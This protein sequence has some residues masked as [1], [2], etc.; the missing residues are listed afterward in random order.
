[1]G[2]QNWIVIDSF[3]FGGKIAPL[4]YLKGLGVSPER[5]RL[6]LAT[7][8]H[9]D[10]VRGLAGLYEAANEADLA[11]SLAL[12]S[13]EFVKFVR[14]QEAGLPGPFTSGVTELEQVMLVN[15]RQA[16][17]PVILTSASHTLFVRHASQTSFG[18]SSRFESLSPSPRDIA[19]FL[20]GLVPL[21]NARATRMATP[22][23]NEASVVGWAA[24]GAA[25]ALLGADLENTADPESGWVA[26]VNSKTLPEGV[27]QVFKVP[28]HGSVT[29]HCSD[30][31]EHL[32]GTNAIAALAPWQRGRSLP[33]DSDID[34]LK[35]HTSD[36]YTARERTTVAYRDG[37][38]PVDKMLKSCGAAI[39]SLPSD[40]GFVQ[41]RCKISDEDPAWSVTLGAGAKRL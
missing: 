24:V 41:M 27:A 36:V 16:R 39:T 33:K 40:Y 12:E 38:K 20:T 30:V 32:L 28:H 10:H 23:R 21:K 2:D 13:D 5:I 37:P 29:G 25:A 11:F 3:S 19:D 9:D 8:W 6:I 31:W 15:E 17:R 4:E 26:I 35:K 7:H 18:K 22:V 34:R 14:E 1:M